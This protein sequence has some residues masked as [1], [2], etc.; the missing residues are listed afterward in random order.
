[1]LTTASSFVLATSTHLP[2]AQLE[3]LQRAGRRVD[4]PQ[5]PDPFAGEST[6]HTQSGARVKKDVS[7]RGLTYGVPSTISATRCAGGTGHRGHPR[8]RARLSS[9]CPCRRL[10]Q[11]PLV[12]GPFSAR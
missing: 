12:P 3:R 2:F 6:S 9:W 8:F 11:R 4:E 5:I 7:G 1:M 10:P